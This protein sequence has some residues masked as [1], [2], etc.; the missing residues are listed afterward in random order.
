MNITDILFSDE[1]MP[2]GMCYLWQPDLLWLHVVSDALIFLAYTSIPITLVYILRIRKDLIF[3][4]VMA[5]FGAFVLLCGFTH[6]ISIWTVWNGA[7]W[8]SG[9]VK[10]VTALVSVATA[11]ML[12]KLV[13]TLK[14]L[15]TVEKLRIEVERRKLAEAKLTAESQRLLDSNDEL[16]A[17]AN[18]SSHDLK[19]PLR[20]IRQL[21]GWIKEDLENEKVV[22]SEETK[23][24]FDLMNSRIIRMETLL[25]DLLEYSKIGMHQNEIT[26]IDCSNL[27]S[28]LFDMLNSDKGIQLH[29]QPGLPAFKTMAAPFAQVLRNLLDNA[30]KHHHDSN[31]NIW[32]KYNELEDYYEFTIQDD[33]PGVNPNDFSK[34]TQLFSTLKPKDEVEGSGMG[35]AIIDKI[36]TNFTGTLNFAANSDSG[37]SVIFTWPKE[38]KLKQTLAQLRE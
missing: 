3:S 35:L 9:S 23:S 14:E 22:L 27:C 8:F 20:G 21:A 38:T 24:H 15:P 2:H 7:Y 31:G 11:I 13:P 4:K 37:L 17:F 34:I 29:L 16:Q 33:G 26:L 18:A 10:G 28:E 5:L 19:S 1:F 30:I 25:E 36:I 6:A 12:W 32:V